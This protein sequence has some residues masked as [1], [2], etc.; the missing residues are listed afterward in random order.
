MG[1]CCSIF[2]IMTQQGDKADKAAKDEKVVNLADARKKQR[3]VQ[4][5]PRQKRASGDYDHA[6]RKQKQRDGSSKLPMS[7]GKRLGAVVQLLVFLL[8][9]YLMLR[10]CQGQGL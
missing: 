10:T 2:P 8:I 4:D 9:C 5:R 7:L 1:G 6:L 3:T